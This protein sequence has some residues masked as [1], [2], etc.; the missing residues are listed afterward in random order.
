MVG[1]ITAT[2]ALILPGV[3]LMLVITLFVKRFAEYEALRHAFTGI[4]LA[5]SALILDTVLKLLKGVFKNRRS[6]IIC[7]IALVL[8]AV[9]S[10][11]P[12]LIILGAGLAGFLLF[13]AP[14]EKK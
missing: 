7:I 2:A 1:G 8:S 10:A 12:V 4:R 11:S 14:P 13:P 5:V 3:L 6:V 9:F